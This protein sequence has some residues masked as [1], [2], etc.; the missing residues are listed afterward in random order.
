M[1]TENY[2]TKGGKGKVIYFRSV[3]RGE[4]DSKSYMGGGF[5]VWVL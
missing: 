5:E 3:A 2:F 4:E 1:I